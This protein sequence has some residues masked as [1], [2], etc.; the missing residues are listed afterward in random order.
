MQRREALAFLSLGTGIGVAALLISCDSDA[1]PDLPPADETD[2]NPGGEPSGTMP[3]A[4]VSSPDACVG[5]TVMMHDTNAQALYLDGSK[6]PLT[7][8]IRVSYVIAG[9][10]ITLD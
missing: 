9:T 4:A 10:A 7:G 5:A 1:G 3:D 2:A 6:G 8:N